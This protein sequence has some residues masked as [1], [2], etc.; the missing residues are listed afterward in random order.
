M[1]NPTITSLIVGS[2]IVSRLWSRSV[3]R[4]AYWCGWLYGVHIS[5]LAEAVIRLPW[6]L[7]FNSCFVRRGMMNWHESTGTS[8]RQ[9]AIITLLGTGYYATM[10]WYLW[11]YSGQQ[12]HKKRSDDTYCIGNCWW[13]AEGSGFNSQL[14]RYFYF[15]RD[16]LVLPSH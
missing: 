8:E 6:D 14:R 15:Y 5:Y 11:R 4:P 2:H 9:A 16:C 7:N 3:P 12:Q 13:Q 10:G 1:S